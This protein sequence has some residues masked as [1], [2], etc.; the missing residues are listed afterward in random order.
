LVTLNTGRA[1]KGGGRGGVGTGCCCCCCCTGVL[2]CG[3]LLGRFDAAPSSSSAAAAAADEVAAA[4][5][6]PPETTPEDAD[7]NDADEGGA[8]G[9]AAVM[10]C[11]CN[12]DL[13]TGFGAGGRR[14]ASLPSPTEAA[15]A[16]AAAAAADAVDSHL[17]RD[18]SCQ[19]P[20]AVSLLNACNSCVTQGLARMLN[21]RT[22]KTKG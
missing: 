20:V 16:A 5:T 21:V 15:A 8:I 6:E 11:S 14:P 7:D 3:P 19:P 10:C 4:T 9:R 18:R 17:K 1:G 12:G 2:S 22:I 13:M